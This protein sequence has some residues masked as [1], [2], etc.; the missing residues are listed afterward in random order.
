MCRLIFR[1]TPYS[2]TEDGDGKKGGLIRR[3]ITRTEWLRG[4][5]S[6]S[7]FA[8][9]RIGCVPQSGLS[10]IACSWSVSVAKRMM[11]V[12]KTVECSCGGDSAKRSDG[13][14]VSGQWLV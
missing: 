10:S 3:E 9:K 13:A 8:R 12:R 7:C 1:K 11:L 5:R 4:R 14:E 2:K 6:E